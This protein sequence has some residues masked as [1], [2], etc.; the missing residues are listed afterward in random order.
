VRV[1]YHRKYYQNGNDAYRLRY[2]L[3]SV[4]K[5]AQNK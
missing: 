2:F 5:A 4:V 1:K 3:K